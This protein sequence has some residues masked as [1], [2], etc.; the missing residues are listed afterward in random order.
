MLPCDSC[1]YVTLEFQVVSLQGCKAILCFLM[2]L[3]SQHK[4]PS[5]KY[6]QYWAKVLLIQC[7]K[8]LARHPGENLRASRQSHRTQWGEQGRLRENGQSH[9]SVWI[10]R[11]WGY[12]IVRRQF[13]GQVGNPIHR[14]ELRPGLVVTE[15][16]YSDSGGWD[17]ARSS[18]Q[19]LKFRSRD[20]VMRQGKAV[21]QLET[22]TPVTL[23]M[24]G[25]VTG[26]SWAGAPESVD[27]V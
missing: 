26:L 9:R 19:E 5:L 4:I 8:S 25:W 22:N 2:L 21:A 16:V 13:W 12:V 20:S 24:L 3:E 18:S 7:Q 17:Q 1:G 15:Q 23:L 6:E 14:S 10:T 27:R 11:V